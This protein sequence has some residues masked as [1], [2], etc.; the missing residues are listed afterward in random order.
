M[1]KIF[2]IFTILFCASSAFCEGFGV[3]FLGDSHLGSDVLIQAFRDEFFAGSDDSVGF[4][5]ATIPK[6]HASEVVKFHN[7]GFEI[8]TSRRD[9]DPAFPLC[10]VIA[11]AK[12]G[13]NLQ[14]ELKKLSGEF[15]VEILHRADANGEIF[16]ISDASG[17][18]VRINHSLKNGWE[19]TKANLS[20]PLQIASLRDGAQLGGYKIYRKNA[21]FADVC[22]SNG[23]YST[24]YT[25]WD[26]NAFVRDFEHLDYDLFIIAYGTNDALDS[27]FE[28]AKFYHSVKSLIRLLRKS[29]KRA[30]IL[31]LAPPRSPKVPRAELTAQILQSLASDMRV[32]FYDL[33]WAM[34]DDGGWDGWREMGLI[35]PDEIHLE[36]AGYEKL[37]RNLGK[38]VKK[39][40]SEF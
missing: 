23:A 1:N 32:M 38:M 19:Y 13:A 21:K 26:E 17:K 8:T 20:F 37:G 4:V 24:L 39:I 36:S 2:V 18:N 25:K 6:F 14:I 15:E 29:S 28:E 34:R 35:R 27:N 22:A 12:N 31:L 33:D 11:T 10:G 16:D 9:I 30:K 3:K 5:P 7:N 40:F